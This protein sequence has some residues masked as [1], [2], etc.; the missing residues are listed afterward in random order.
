[1]QA[2]LIYE[3]KRNIKQ[4]ILKLN[5]NNKS[6]IQYKWLNLGF[7]FI[8]QIQNCMVI[9]HSILFPIIKISPA[10]MDRVSEKNLPYQLNAYYFS[11]KFSI[12][13]FFSGNSLYSLASTFITSCLD[14]S[15]FFCL[16]TAN[17]SC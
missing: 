10:F 11:K 7:I 9:A 2:N 15:G 4:L 5:V 17:F 14:M 6:F 1:M 8:I 13:F 3:N 12:T 16:K